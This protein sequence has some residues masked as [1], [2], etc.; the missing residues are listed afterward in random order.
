MKS[1]QINYIREWAASGNEWRSELSQMGHR[2]PMGCLEFIGRGGAYN[3]DCRLSS[4]GLM[5]AKLIQENETLRKRE[6][7]Q[8]RK[9]TE[10]MTFEMDETFL[11]RECGCILIAH[12]R[13]GYWE[14]E[15]GNPCDPDE[16]LFAGSEPWVVP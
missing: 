6:Q 11:I 7:P 16:V 2:L 13:T 9:V 10:E 15:D 1:E 4:T 5:V 14:D 12:M 8:W 3:L